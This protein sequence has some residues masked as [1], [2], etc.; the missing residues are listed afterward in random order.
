[1]SAACFHTDKHLLFLSAG[2]VHVYHNA[3]QAALSNFTL[4]TEGIFTHMAKD[5][6]CSKCLLYCTC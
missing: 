5:E 2:K 6:G 4:L 1:M 3:G